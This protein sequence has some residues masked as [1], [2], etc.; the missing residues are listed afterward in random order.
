[1]DIQFDQT[2]GGSRVKILTVID[3]C[4]REPLATDV[5][6]AIDGTSRPVGQPM[7]PMGIIG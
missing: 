2:G 4:T 7:I 6:R 3:E 5:A 1:M